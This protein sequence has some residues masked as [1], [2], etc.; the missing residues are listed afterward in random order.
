ML[1]KQNKDK[2]VL[3]PVYNDNKTY[4]DLWVQSLDDH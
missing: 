4:T 1:F 3:Q 2:V